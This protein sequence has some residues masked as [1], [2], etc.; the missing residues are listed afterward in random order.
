MYLT[1]LPLAAA[2]FL[3][4]KFVIHEPTAKDPP[5]QRRRRVDAA[6]AG[7]DDRPVVI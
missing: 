6:L 1:I 3:D 7:I 4:G 5:V 2:L